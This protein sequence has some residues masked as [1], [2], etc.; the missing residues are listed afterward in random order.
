LKE[1]VWKLR[2]PRERRSALIQSIAPRIY[3][4]GRAL[5][6]KGGGEKKKKR[7]KGGKR[8]AMK[9]GKGK[10]QGALL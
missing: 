5:S 10:K 8:G 3:G 6:A 1:K 9:R 7:G 2:I 4:G